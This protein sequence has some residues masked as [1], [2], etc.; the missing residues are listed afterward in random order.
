VAVT[1]TVQIAARIPEDLEDALKDRAKEE[2]RTVSWLIRQALKEYVGY[3]P[4]K[5][6]AAA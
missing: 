3:E 6:D 1:Q 4:Q 5:E 2:D